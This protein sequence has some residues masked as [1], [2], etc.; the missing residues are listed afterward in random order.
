MSLKEVVKFAAW[1]TSSR[2]VEPMVP[3]LAA[4]MQF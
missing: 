3:G 1:R 4:R 2:I